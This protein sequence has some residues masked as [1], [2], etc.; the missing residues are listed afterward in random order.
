MNNELKEGFISMA[1]RGTIVSTSDTIAIP[2]PTEDVIYD[3]AI[4][5]YRHRAFSYFTDIIYNRLI[6]EF[7]INMAY[8]RQ[9][10]NMHKG[11][12]L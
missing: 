3:V 4:D 10:K 8:Y 2:E 7:D 12:D 6:D 9:S 1:S 11:I 5:S